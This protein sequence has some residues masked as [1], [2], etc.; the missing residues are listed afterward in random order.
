MELK[1]IYVSLIRSVCEY[2]CPVWSTG[3]TSELSDM[4]ESIQRRALR[5]ILPSI[6]YELACDR[7]E[8]PYLADRRK[9]LCKTFFEQMKDP[10]HKLNDLLPPK[11]SNTYNFRRTAT[12]PLP[13]CQTSRYKNSF[14]P[15]C[16]FNCQ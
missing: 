3:L 7:L 10:S 4:L 5:V 8:L 6:T 13:K 14:V 11:R 2:A 9:E 15:W 12:Y 16:L 1:T